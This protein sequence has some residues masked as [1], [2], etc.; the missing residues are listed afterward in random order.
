MG[1]D[2]LQ[3]DAMVEDF[4]DDVLPGSRTHDGHHLVYVQ[5]G[6][7]TEQRCEIDENGDIVVTGPLDVVDISE[8]EIWCHTCDESVYADGESGLSEEWMVV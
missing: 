6:C 2:V 4:F 1:D 7:S 8:N 3:D 5:T